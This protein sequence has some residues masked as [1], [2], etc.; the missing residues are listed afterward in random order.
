[1][2]ASEKALPK[3]RIVKSE[4]SSVTAPDESKQSFSAQTWISASLILVF[5]ALAS[6]GVGFVREILVANY[7]GASSQIDAFMVALS[8]PMLIG[9]GIG[10][11]LSNALVPMYRKV[12]A[13]G[14]MIRAN[15]L[16]MTVVV[17]GCIASILLML[18]LC[19]MPLRFI[20][21]VAPSL[22]KST[23]ALAGELTRWLS[24][25]VLGLI[26]TYI[27]TAVYH[28][29]HHFKI[30]AS[31]EL[32][33]NGMMILF[34][35][36]LV[37]PLGVYALVF[38]CIFGVFLCVGIQVSFLLKR[39]LPGFGL[40]FQGADIKALITL[41]LPILFFDFSLQFGTVVENYFASGL[42]E[43]SIA[44]LNYAK[45]LYMSIIGL[46]A[47]SVSR[48]VFPTL[49]ALS[50]E[51]KQDEAKDLFV[52]LNK[53]LIILFIPLTVLLVLF[54]KEVIQIVFMRG[55]FDNA[56]SELTSAAF[57][58]YAA[59]LL[60][61]AVEPLFLRACYA[62]SDALTPLLSAILSVLC[63]IPLSYFLRPLLGLG[64]I[65]L[66]MNL[67]F[68]LRLFIQGVSIRKKLGGLAIREMMKTV[69]V[70]LVCALMALLPITRLPKDHIVN[71]LIS[72]LLFFILYIGVGLLLMTKEIKT[73]WRSLSQSFAAGSTKS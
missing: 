42:T 73:V 70:S 5:V 51:Q 24:L 69:V 15:R 54:R 26:L 31:S 4:W 46:V 6:K 49:S 30:P 34:L 39:R 25:Y 44:A 48:G 45:R 28:A 20:E 47:I 55:S 23:S 14:G 22:T 32:A 17:C 12:L 67:A 29:F 35:I 16:A 63:A 71:L 18:P 13:S 41:A 9:G 64:G 53:Q 58:F 38:G 36:A 37:L 19:V 57:L 3:D 50:S 59:G 1:M 27:L 61:A 66:A 62:F 60:I 68:L 72:F 8:L 65:A 52:K 40:Y 56:A 2:N 7:F 43:G 21:L 33:F 11:A 10:F